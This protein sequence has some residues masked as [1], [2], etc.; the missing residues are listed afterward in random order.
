[1]IK[2]GPKRPV[3]FLRVGTYPSLFEFTGSMAS[4]EI[5]NEIKRSTLMTWLSGSHYMAIGVL[6]TRNAPNSYEVEWQTIFT[7]YMFVIIHLPHFDSSEPSVQSGSPSHLKFFDIQVPSGHL[8]SCSLQFL[9]DINTNN[10]ILDCW[11]LLNENSLLLTYSNFC[12]IH[13]KEIIR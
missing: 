6:M 12:V 7:F 4:V 5:T 9:K 3:R 13:F 11:F 1:M 8:Y 10:I 2:I